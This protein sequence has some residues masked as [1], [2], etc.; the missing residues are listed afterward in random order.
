MAQVLC[1]ASAVLAGG[2]A[3]VATREESHAPLATSAA[4]LRVLV[5]GARRCVAFLGATAAAE[6]VL[7][8]ETFSFAASELVRQTA[9]WSAPL[10]TSDAAALFCV[11]LALGGVVGG[12]L[13]QSV[14]GV[15]IVPLATLLLVRA[16]V[17]AKKRL[18]SQTL[19]QEMPGVLRTMSSA[20]ASG[21]TLIQAVEYVGL[22]ERGPAAQA[23]V[24]ASLRLRCG[25]SLEDTLEELRSELAAPGV[26]LMVTALSI[27]QRTGSPLRDLLQ[28]S[29]ELVE[30]QR[31][32]ERML[33][34]RTAQARLSVR[35]VCSLP[36]LIVCVLAAISPDFRAGVLSAPGIVSLALAACMDAAALLIIRHIMEGVL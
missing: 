21:N 3:W 32:F 34:V 28:R 8:N 6:S 2:A 19:A 33:S 27:S 31:E 14:V 25:M 35:I 11:L 30:Q 4:R 23:F 17:S 18:V 29:A 22:H 36:P 9:A 1:L 26:D 20:L 5:H 10:S 7:A 24:R 13:T 16:R 12:L 15:P